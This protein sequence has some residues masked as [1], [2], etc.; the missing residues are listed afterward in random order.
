MD[1][2]YDVIRKQIESLCKLP[3]AFGLPVLEAGF[4]PRKS[5][6]RDGQSVTMRYV[7]SVTVD[8]FT[9]N[10]T[11][12]VTGKAFCNSRTPVSV[13]PVRCTYSFR[14]RVRP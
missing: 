12:P 9:T 10:Y 8:G 14:N 2:D 7:V 4:V 13:A 5:G 11:Y 6:P 1:T 3:V